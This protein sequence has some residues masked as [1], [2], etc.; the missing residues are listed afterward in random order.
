MRAKR[1]VRTPSLALIVILIS[2]TWLTVAHAQSEGN[3][4]VF[5]S[6]GTAVVGSAAI[7]D[8]TPFASTS[9]TICKTIYNILKSPNYP[10]GLAGSSGKPGGA[11]IDARG[12]TSSNSN[13]TCAST[14][15]PWYDGTNYLDYPSVVLLPAGT[16]T[17]S[18]TWLIPNNTKIIGQG[19]S[20]PVTTGT[21][22]GTVITAASG[23][24]G[25][26]STY[27]P[28]LAII[29]FGEP[30][31]T[32]TCST[33]DSGTN[34][35]CFHIS[36]E[37]LTLNNALSSGGAANSNIDGVLNLNSQELTYVRRVNL[38]GITGTGLQVGYTNYPFQAQNSGP[39]Q[40]ISYN[41]PTGITGKYCAQIYG[42]GTR[43]IHGIKCNG[44]SG[45]AGI[46]ID[47]GSNSI[48]D[49]YVNG[50][51]DGILLGSQSSTNSRA[52]GNL[53]SNITG[54]TSITNLV[55]ICGSSAT[56]NCPGSPVSLPRDNTVLALTSDNDSSSTYSVVD[57]VSNS[58][59]TTATDASLAIY[60]L[61][62]PVSTGSSRFS[63]SPSVPAWF[64]GSTQTPTGTCSPGSI[65]SATGT[66]GS[67]TLWGCLTSGSSTSWV[68][69]K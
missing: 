38:Y 44:D 28:A 43:G 16:I 2:A 52:W 53:I 54:G 48:E 42:A 11:V 19:A 35:V 12:L 40:S 9:T 4:A 47:S 32:Y 51:T 63:T 29:Q 56:G 15:T 60:A 62:E 65:Y 27:S 18:Y 13:L 58:S 22:T 30:T 59:L 5:N 25:L 7:F 61:G 14:E 3:N 6:A 8:A 1:F 67:G 17:I 41:V 69:E 21:Q 55:H 66:S 33:T 49:V 37:D 20:T 36:V 24:S 57:G 64:V 39:Y 26:S 50:F 10:S 45:T 31:G 68:L 34:G 23:F 46:L